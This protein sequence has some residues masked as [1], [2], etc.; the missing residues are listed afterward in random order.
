M[1]GTVRRTGIDLG[2]APSDGSGAPRHLLRADRSDTAGPLF[3]STSGLIVT[4]HQRA[5]L[6]GAWKISG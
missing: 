5:P 2:L 3:W 1:S 6:L 4:Q